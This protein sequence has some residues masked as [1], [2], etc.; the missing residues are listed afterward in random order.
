MQR[1]IEMIPELNL[2][3]T[4][5]NRGPHLGIKRHLDVDRI[6]SGGFEVGEV[7]DMAG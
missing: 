2:S 3:P 5:E 6:A 7:I 1:I 4:I